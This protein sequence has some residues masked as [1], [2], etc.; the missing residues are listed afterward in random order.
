MWVAV[1]VVTVG[2]EPSAPQCTDI[3]QHLLAAYCA[4]M[5]AGMCAGMPAHMY[6]DMCIGPRGW[7]YANIH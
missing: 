4:D 2:D 3:A 6:A 5:C 1:V 7:H